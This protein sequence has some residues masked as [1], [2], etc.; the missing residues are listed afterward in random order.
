LQLK[1]KVRH[2]LRN[3][4]NENRQTIQTDRDTLAGL[5]LQLK[6][7]QQAAGVLETHITT[8][9]HSEADDIWDGLAFDPIFPSAEPSAE[10]SAIN[11]DSIPGTNPPHKT[12]PITYGPIPIEDH[13]IALPSNRNTNNMYRE[14]EL[15]HRISHAEQQLNQIRQLIAEK[16]FQFSHIRRVAPRKGVVTRSRG[17]VKKLNKTI[18]EHCRMYMRCR[19]RLVFLGAEPQVL[20]RLQVLNPVDIHA[21]TAIL[22]PNEPGSTRIK[23]PW[24]WQTAARHY[25]MSTSGAEENAETTAEEL[26]SL[27]ECEFILPQSIII[28]TPYQFGGFTGYALELNVRGGKKRLH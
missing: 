25:G 9:S 12:T 5:I 6:Q 10:P 7:A 26:S 1:A 13:V 22:N 21:S 24:I 14:L 8:I 3:P 11:A 23:L 20:T 2:L 27:V 15:G 17:V 18:A 19:S 28:F 4:G 16:S